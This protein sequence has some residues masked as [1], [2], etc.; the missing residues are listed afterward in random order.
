LKVLEIRYLELSRNVIQAIFKG[1]SKNKHL[2]RLVLTNNALK[3]AN[4]HEY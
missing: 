2:I 1:L 4:R 3:N